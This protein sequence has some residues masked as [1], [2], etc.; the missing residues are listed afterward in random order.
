[1]CLV[2]HN[3]LFSE[4][5]LPSKLTE[6]LLSRPANNSTSTEKYEELLRTPTAQTSAAC[7]GIH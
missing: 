2:I 4:A 5:L 3:A 6:K 7:Y 1:M